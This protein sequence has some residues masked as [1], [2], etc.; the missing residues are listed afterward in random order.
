M[1]PVY[2]R[3]YYLRFLQDALVARCMCAGKKTS[4]FQTVKY[5]LMTRD[6]E[7]I[8]GE[9]HPDDVPKEK[10]VEQRPSFLR[11]LLGFFYRLSLG[12]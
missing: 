11:R 1:E 7:D 12:C 8:V 2:G 3:Y 9:I 4:V 5:G 10:S 6:N